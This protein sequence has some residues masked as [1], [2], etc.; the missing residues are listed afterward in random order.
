MESFDDDLPISISTMTVVVPIGAS[1][2][3]RSLFP[4]IPITFPRVASMDQLDY[5]DL[6]PIKSKSHKAKPPFCDV[7]GSILRAMYLN[8]TRGM[9]KVG[10]TFFRNSITVDISTS[11]KNV[12]VKIYRTK[13]HLCGGTSVDI[14]REAVEYL[15]SMIIEVDNMLKFIRDHWNQCEEIF[16]WYEENTKS[17]EFDALFDPIIKDPLDFLDEDAEFDYDDVATMREKIRI[18]QQI[19]DRFYDTEESKRLSSFIY[20]RL[21]DVKYHDTFVKTLEFIRS[22]DSVFTGTMEILELEKVMINFNFNLGYRIDRCKMV[23]VISGINGFIVRFKT[24][25][26]HAVTIKLPSGEYNKKGKEKYSTFNV[27]KSG[28]VTQSGPDEEVMKE[29]RILFI[30]TLNQHKHLFIVTDDQTA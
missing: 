26:N 23:E 1:I 7:P 22:K 14:V 12:S 8:V 6:S 28:L 30:Y 27:Y 9:K 18:P 4:L 21:I 25:V 3:I 15:R 5:I 19:P 24:T 29:S 11:K 13:F 17:G 10:E 16:Q 2:D 20:Q